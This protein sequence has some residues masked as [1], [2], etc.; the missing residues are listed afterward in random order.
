MVSAP[1]RSGW[2]IGHLVVSVAASALVLAPG[3]HPEEN[4]QGVVLAFGLVLIG[5]CVA[6]A[7][8][9]STKSARRP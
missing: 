1:R 6:D 9:R 4:A 5:S 8:A 7:I 2:R 3:F